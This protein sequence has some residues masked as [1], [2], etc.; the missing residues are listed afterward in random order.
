MFHLKPFVAP[1]GTKYVQ[2]FALGLVLKT[3]LGIN[4]ATGARIS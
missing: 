3:S 2:H 1:L 4:H